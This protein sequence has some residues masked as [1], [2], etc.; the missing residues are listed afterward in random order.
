MLSFIASLDQR[1][2]EVNDDS[3]VVDDERGGIEKARR[4]ARLSYCNQ[5]RER[6]HELIRETS[7]LLPELLYYKRNRQI[8]TRGRGIDMEPQTLL[9]TVTRGETATVEFKRCG[10]QPAEDTFQTVCSFANHM[11]G[12]I[13]LGV[14]DD[15]KVV[16][17]PAGAAADIQ[18][19]I[20]NVARN[21]KLFDPPVILETEAITTCDATVIRIWVPM[22]PD[23]HRFKGIVY[24][25]IADT[26]VRVVASSQVSSMYIRKS[27]QE[28]ERRIFPYLEVGDLRH[29][30]IDRARKLATARRP[31]HPWQKLGDEQLL[32]S[33]QLLVKDFSTG[34]V[35]LTLAAGLLFGT[36]DVIGSLCPAYKT[37]AVV[38]LRDLDRY[39]DR[40][41]V[42]TNLIDAYDDLMGF[43]ERH[44][45]DPFVLEDNA[46]VSVRGIVCRE[47]ISNLLIH[48][49]FTSPF[50]AKLTIDREGLRTENA[51]RMYFEGAITLKDFSPM[52]KNPSIANVF[53][54]IG[55]AEELGSGTRNLFKY[56][57]AFMG[58]DPSLVDGG[59]F[60]A[61]IP[62][63]VGLLTGG[64]ASV[65]KTLGI[66]EAILRLASSVDNF[67][68][69]QAAEVAGVSKRSA[70]AHISTLIEAGALIG[71]GSTRDRCF[72]RR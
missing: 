28:T 50:P 2:A 9:E 36:D 18:R 45:P 58:G 56:S 70:S 38:R 10:S 12:S 29:D 17:V 61:K 72:R 53:T 35:G 41:V 23:V 8:C 24:D 32:R 15:G 49:E 64:E 11:G 69:A 52:P 34:Q 55:L 1:L 43:C 25:R 33:A 16:G 68:L 60:C 21:P 14:E 57:K 67:T 4:P 46:R 13:F 65:R 6:I 26:D 51:S 20:A 37:D 5:I 39:D 31:G 40:L 54:Q 48:R 27:N 62:D 42:K 66:D 59:T 63:V 47:L 3:I 30:L 44:L 22:S 71:E 7:N 19:N